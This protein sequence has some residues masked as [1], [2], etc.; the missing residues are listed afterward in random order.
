MASDRYSRQSFLGPDAEERIGN[1]TI[2]IPGL[3]GGGSHIVQQLAH[4]GF[5]RFILYDWDAVEDSNLN[6]LVGATNADALAGTPKLHLA[7]MM[8]Y[9]LQPDA[10]VEAY[11]CRWQEDPGPLRRCQIVMGCVGSFKGREELEVSSRRYLAHY[12]DIGM[13]VHGERD[14]VIGGQ[15]ILSSPGGPCMRCMG[16]LTDEVLGREGARY[17]TAGARPQVIW[18][19]GVLASTAVG[20]AVD[21]VT[22]WTRIRRTHAYLSYDGNQGTLAESLTLR[23]LPVDGCPHFPGGEVGDPVFRGL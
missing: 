13:D 12:I 23:G 22:G 9:G 8:I 21:L 18:P 1:V 20:L 16:F 5:K 6:R 3:G 17:G 10:L 19:N 11:P 2:G 14:P 15:V 4:V 7:K